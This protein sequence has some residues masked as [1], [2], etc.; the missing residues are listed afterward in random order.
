[1]KLSL[2]YLADFRALY[3][4]ASKPAESLIAKEPDRNNT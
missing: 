3:P 1:M 4:T 2:G